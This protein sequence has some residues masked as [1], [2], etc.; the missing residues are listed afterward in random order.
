MAWNGGVASSKANEGD[1]PQNSSNGSDIEWEYALKCTDDPSDQTDE[2]FSITDLGASYEFGIYDMRDHIDPNGRG[3]D[4]RLTL[5][6][7]A[8]GPS[9]GD[10]DTAFEIE[11]FAQ[12]EW[13]N[14]Y[15]HWL[16]NELVNRNEGPVGAQT[17]C[18]MELVDPN[19]PTIIVAPNPQVQVP[20]GEGNLTVRALATP[21]FNAYGAALFNDGATGGDITL[22][23]LSFG[24]AADGTTYTVGDRQLSWTVVLVRR[25]RSSDDEW[26]LAPSNLQP[27]YSPPTP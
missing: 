25:R 17:S 16:T 6:L 24:G 2:G 26:V 27:S 19:Q 21:A 20:G 1:P 23:P 5:A 11:V 3:D 13:I 22:G 4:A 18:R 7:V 14:Q 10:I 8:N 15:E 12:A 9:V